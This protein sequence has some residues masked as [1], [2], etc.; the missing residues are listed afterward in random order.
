MPLVS[1]VIA[2]YKRPEALRRAIDTVLRQTVG[3]LEVVVAVESDD[4]VSVPAIAAIGDPRVRHVVMPR[5]GGPGPARDLGARSS[6]GKW[7]AFLDDD[8]E[9]LPE[10]LG[11]QLAAMPDDRCI[12]M[13]LT[14]ITTP[15]GVFVHPRVV[16]EGDGPIDE[17][18]FDRK[19]WLKGG[20]G[21]LQTSSLIVPR[22]L[23]DLLGFGSARH[24][25]WEFAIRAVKQHG[26]RLVTV[27]E[28]LVVYH[29]GGRYPWRGSAEWIDSVRDLVTKRAYSGFC[30]TVATQG[31]VPRERNLAFVTLLGMAFRNGR[32]TGRQLFAF[33]LIWVLSENLRHRIRLFLAARR[34]E[35]KQKSP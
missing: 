11:R 31:L 16:Y 18:L 10:K 6:T 14:R 26:Y 24:E 35:P 15:N 3:D 22:A 25:E 1:V 17:W 34:G 23:F 12:G 7:I 32:P 9:W 13:T 8:D 28:P 33:L 27:R 2:T 20:E 21:M 5:R 4:T 30:L 19:S 29:A